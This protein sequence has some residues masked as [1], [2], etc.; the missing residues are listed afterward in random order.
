MMKMK[1][2][3]DTPRLTVRYIDAATEEIIF[4]VLDRNWMNVAE[5]LSDVYVAKVMEAQFGNSAPNNLMI[6]V[7]GDYTRIE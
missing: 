3:K 2:T 4:E 1:Y 5:L 7:I 6:L